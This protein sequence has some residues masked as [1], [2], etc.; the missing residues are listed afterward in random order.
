M[1]FTGPGN[2]FGAVVSNLRLAVEGVFDAFANQTAQKH[3]KDEV[4]PQGHKITMGSTT[5][6]SY[7]IGGGGDHDRPDGWDCPN[8][9]SQT[10][11][12]HSGGGQFGKSIYE[13]KNGKVLITL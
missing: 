1:I 9:V 3:Q 10:S 13:Y 2:A 6:P 5:P 4:V 8:G 7:P 12:N 11:C